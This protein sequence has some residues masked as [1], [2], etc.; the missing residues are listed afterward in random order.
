MSLSAEYEALATSTL[1]DVTRDIEALPDPREVARRAARAITRLLGADTAVYFTL[2]DQRQHV[3][4][5]AGYRVPPE[6]VQPGFR[7]PTGD[8]PEAIRDAS[9]RR[10]PLASTSVPEDA[11]FDAPAIRALPL[12]PKG[13]LCAPATRAGA[14]R[15]ALIVCW[16]TEAHEPTE[17]EMGVATAVATHVAIALDASRAAWVLAPNKTLFIV[18]R[19]NDHLYRSLV[20]TFAGDDTVEIVLDRRVG[21]RREA[22]EATADQERRERDRRRLADIERQLRR[23]GWAV[24]TVKP[25]PS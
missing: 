16:W 20:R 19:H 5:I 6:L 22:V 14:V 3:T 4:A 10:E 9:R 7:V 18:A 24:V 2:D 21:Q 17:H 15:G 8:V 12:Q 25:F 1:L 11:R 13:M 23:R